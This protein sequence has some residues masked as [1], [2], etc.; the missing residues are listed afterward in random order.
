MLE[1]ALLRGSQFAQRLLSGSSTLRSNAVLGYGIGLAAF[2]CALAI[3]FWLEPAIPYFPY[4]TFIPAVIITAFL[5]GSRAGLFCA[6]LSFLSAWYLFVDPM[7][8]FST[9]FGAVVGL[10]LFGFIISVDIAIIEIAAKTVDRLAAQEA[11]LNTIV[12]TV[13]VGLLM[14]DLPSGKIVGG[15]KYVEDMLRHP[16]RHSPNIEGYGEWVSFHEDGSRVEG[17]E[18]PLAAI[19]LR[20]EEN[21]NMEVNY[22][23]GDGSKAWI[24]IA[25]RPVRDGAGR[26]IGGVAAIIDIDEQRKTQIALEEAL[27]VKEVLLYEVNHRV[28]NSLQLVSSI[29]LLEAAK[30]TNDEAR[31]AVMV[32]RNKVDLVARLHQLLYGSG[33]HDRVDLKT[34]LEDIVRHLI[35]SAGRDDVILEFNFSSDLNIGI[36]EASPLVLV[37]NEIITNSL[38]YGLSSER[39]KLTIT[40]NNVSDEMMLEI[41]DNGPGISATTTEKK[42]SMGSEIVTGLVSQMR[43]TLVIQS[44]SSGT[45][46]ILTVPL[47]SQSFDQ[48]GTRQ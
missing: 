30:I 38:K 1:A 48:K 29:L 15:N 14:A 39:P 6:A 12:E 3:R 35:L 16:L 7:A 11:Q 45:A 8:P 5:A 43:G 33:A 24:R 19:M 31:A 40:A 32:A 13:P 17:Y 41:R 42:P 26:I 34:A 36:R 37:V 25:A 21:P 44:D 18:Y 47:D 23:R 22:Q 46:N 9:S 2:M 28:K 4:I 20:G 10:G 27:Q